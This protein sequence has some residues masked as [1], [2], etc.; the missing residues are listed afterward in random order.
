MTYKFFQIEPL[1]TW[2]ILA[3]KAPRGYGTKILLPGHMEE[4]HPF[5]S[6]LDK[7]G[8]SIQKVITC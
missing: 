8:L 4:T 2:S 7:K 1:K 3:V 5:S 6:G